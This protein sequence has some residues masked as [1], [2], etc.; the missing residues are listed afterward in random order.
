MGLPE[1]LEMRDTSREGGG[2][3]LDVLLRLPSV[4]APAPV[5]GGERQ[6]DVP[7]LPTVYVRS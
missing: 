5:L 2:C 3:Q 6:K 7:H 4:D 1:P